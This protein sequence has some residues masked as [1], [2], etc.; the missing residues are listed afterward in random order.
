MTDTPITLT[1]TGMVVPLACGPAYFNHC[2]LRDACPGCIDPQTRER[3]FD[4]AS[5]AGLPRARAARIDGGALVVDWQTEQHSS[6]I[7]LAL[8][9]SFAA[10]GRAED[11][12][13][14]PRRL[15][16]ADHAP[17]IVRVPQAAVLTDPAA[18]ACLTHAL[19][20]DGIAIVTDMAADDDS[21]PRLAHAFG[22]ITPSAE[23]L[24]FDVRVEIAP[25]NLAF[26]AGP[27]E[28]HTDLP[29]EEAA[30]GVQFPHCLERVYSSSASEWVHSARS[31]EDLVEILIA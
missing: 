31:E 29:G 28:M 8:L 21:L 25:T 9:E 2:W 4:V 12:A 6:R 13:D 19:I 30:P 15:W 24:F 22:P 11:P 18:R 3:I 7:P 26:T 16:Y 27:L 20:E 1:D 5:L 10:R 14:L 23:G 17:R